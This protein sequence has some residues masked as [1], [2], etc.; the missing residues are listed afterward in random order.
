MLAANYNA[1]MQQGAMTANPGELTLML[2]DG[3]IKFLR[4]A[5]ACHNENDYCGF[6][7]N[8]QRVQD[9]LTELMTTLDFQY[10]IAHHLYNLYSFFHRETVSINIKK[11]ASKITQIVDL[12]VDLR[13]T[14]QEVIRINRKYEYKAGVFE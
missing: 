6:N 2:Y 11:E 10:D 3:C 5:Q 1:Y 12:I 14:W 13:N 4:K 9:I 8:I 7:T